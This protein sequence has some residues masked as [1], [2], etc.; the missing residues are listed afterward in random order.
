MSCCLI[1][2]ENGVVLADA[3]R[4]GELGW[5]IGPRSILLTALRASRKALFSFIA[6]I[7]PAARGEFVAGSENLQD[8][9]SEIND[10]DRKLLGSL[11]Q[12]GPG[13][14]DDTWSAIW[15]EANTLRPKVLKQL[16]HRPLSGAE[17]VHNGASDPTLYGSAGELVA[18]ERRAAIA[19]RKALSP[20]GIH[21]HE[22]IAQM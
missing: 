21:W 1:D 5:H 6:L 9:L 19:L 10:A 20:D 2:L 8:V 17:P 22:L 15:R 12:P 13:R 11:G 7:P 18:S 3:H 16:S 4:H 14:A